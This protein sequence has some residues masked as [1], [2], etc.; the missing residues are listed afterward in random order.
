MGDI[1]AKRE[2]NDVRGVVD[3]YLRLLELGVPG[4]IYNV[5]SSRPVSVR[6][7]LSHLHA[8]TGRELH[9]VQNPQFM[10]RNEITCLVGN[11]QKLVNALGPVNWRPLD[12]TLQ[13]M[14]DAASTNGI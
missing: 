11:G 12:E 13:W 6:S 4:K 9:V 14:L 2:Y 8:V 3:I 10:R 7:V 5:A 1:D